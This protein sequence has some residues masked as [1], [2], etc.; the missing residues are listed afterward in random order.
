MASSRPLREY[1][2][3]HFADRSLWASGQMLDLVEKSWSSGAPATWETA[4]RV[5]GAAVGLEV[6]SYLST[7]IFR[8]AIDF[9]QLFARQKLERL[10]MA[11]KLNLIM[12]DYDETYQ[13][14]VRGGVRTSHPPP[15]T[16][17]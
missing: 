11:A 9:L 12:S 16:A 3:L 15:L 5:A 8:G 10:Y 2:S 7:D 1:P 17:G 14:V 6:F 4:L 13:A